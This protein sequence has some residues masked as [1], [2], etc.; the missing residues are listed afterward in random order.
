MIDF[1]KDILSLTIMYMYYKG[2]TILTSWCLGGGGGAEIFNTLAL[3]VWAAVKL[4]LSF[5]K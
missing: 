2:P 5:W 4:S 3:D 1:L